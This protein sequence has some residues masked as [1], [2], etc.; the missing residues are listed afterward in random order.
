MIWKDPLTGIWHSPDW[1]LIW[2]RR[3]V[4][5]FFLQDAKAVWWLPKQLVRHA[6]AGTKNDANHELAECPDSGDK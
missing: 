6:V 1:G 3:H 4:C 2:G 5:V